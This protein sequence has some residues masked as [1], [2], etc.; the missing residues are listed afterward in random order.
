[1]CWYVNVWQTLFSDGKKFKEK[2]DNIFH[3]L[4]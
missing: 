1:M 4:L 3:K 2:I